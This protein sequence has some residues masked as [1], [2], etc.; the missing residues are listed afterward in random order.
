MLADQ[1]LQKSFLRQATESQLEA[2]MGYF[3]GAAFSQRA[4]FTL[5]EPNARVEELTGVKPEVSGKTPQWYWEAVH[6]ADREEVKRQFQHAAQSPGGVTTQYRIRHATT[7]KITYLFEHRQAVMGA[8]GEAAGYR[9]LWLDLTSQTVA[10]TRLPTAAWAEALT[11]LTRAM[12][13]DFNN[14]IAG[15]LGMSEVLLMQ[16]GANDP[17][18]RP[19]EMVK[20]NAMRTTQFVKRMGS[21]YRGGSGT[22]EYVDLN[23][24]VSEL[25][26]TLGRTLPRRMQIKAE[27]APGNLP[28][29][30]DMAEFGRVVVGL[31]LNAAEAMPNGGELILRATAHT[32]APSLTYHRGQFPRLPCACF[33]AQDKGCG[34]ATRHLPALFEPFFS[35]KPLANA[36]GLGLYYARQ[37]AE[38]HGGAV[39]VESAEG[40]GTTV[41][42]WLPQADF[43]NPR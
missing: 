38:K 30:L 35:T 24:V 3:S 34:I 12:V 25:C 37:F 27:P 28:V 31:G 32:T 18:R 43:S 9:V 40:S 10:Q 15:V 2:V 42:L 7:G 8:S 1:D 5:A 41:Q 29:Y 21:L 39:S 17:K 36:S 14:F 13:H 22:R 19:L 6:E 16:L 4:D 20:Q 23:Q 26:E 11:V 33:S